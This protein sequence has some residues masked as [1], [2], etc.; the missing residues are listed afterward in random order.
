MSFTSVMF[1]FI[2]FPITIL[3]YNIAKKI[4]LKFANFVLFLSNLGFYSWAGITGVVFLVV[5][6]LIVYFLGRIAYFTGAYEKK[7]DKVMLYK[8]QIMGL[9]LVIL[10]SILFSYKYYNFILEILTPI[11]NIALPKLNLIAPLGISYLIFSGISYIMDIYR[12]DAMPGTLI[13]TGNYI[14]FFPKIA[15]GPIA[16]YKDFQME[17]T[18]SIDLEQAMSGLNRIIIGM[19][20]KLIFADYFGMVLATIPHEGIDQLTAFLTIIIYSLQLIFDFAGY[21]DMAIGLGTLYGYRLPENFHYPY[22]SFSIT[23]FWRRWHI[24]LGRF[25]RDYLYIPLGGNRKGKN[26]TYLNLFVVFLATGI[27]H[28]AGWN[29]LIWGSLH[30][31]CV[32]FERIVK[33]NKLLQR[34]PSAVKWICTITI[35]FIGWQF[36]RFSDIEGV[37]E[38]FYRIYHKSDGTVLFTWKYYLTNKLI[39]LSLI[40][41]FIVSFM[42][43]QVIQNFIN[44]IKSNK[45]VIIIRQIVLLALFIFTIC[46]MVSSTYSPFLYFRY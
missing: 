23:D 11:S 29:Y 45:I 5:Y 37:H 17:I 34:I 2:F 39:V 18:K 7:T 30:G 4:N 31:I 21:S 1:L 6:I 27:W 20:K 22:L 12:G 38:L 10:L 3:M 28:G 44:R 15:C 9:V 25:F 16:L 14:S 42:G 8:K 33:N 36:F 24:S 41:F 40:G 26:R 43:T 35:V 46:S 13:E 32:I 19:A